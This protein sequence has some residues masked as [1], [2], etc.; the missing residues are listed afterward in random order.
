MRLLAYAEGAQLDTLGELIGGGNFPCEGLSDADYRT[1]LYAQ[2]QINQSRGEPERLI[3][4]LIA[5]TGTTW[6]KFSELQPAQIYM[7]YSGTTVPSFLL[8]SMKRIKAAG[9]RL[10]IARVDSTTPF[11]FAGGPTSEID[12]NHGFSDLSQLTGGSLGE[13]IQ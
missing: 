9:V 7:Q 10:D 2:C 6:T 12:S 13:I 3:A 4:A 8:S 5:L 11:M 1:R